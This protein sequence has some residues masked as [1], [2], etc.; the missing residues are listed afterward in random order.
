MDEEI[1]RE[2]QFRNRLLVEGED[3]L[4]VCIHLLKAHQI[5]IL[6][7]ERS[8]KNKTVGK[9]EIEIVSKGGVERLLAILSE[10]LQGSDLKH[11]GVLVDADEDFTNR[12]RSLRDILVNSGYSTIPSIPH[13]EGTIIK[14]SDKPTVGIWIMPDNQLPGM[15]EHFCES[16]VPT[17]D[18]LW[19]TAGIALH[20][21]IEQDRRF[22]EKHMIKAHLHT[23]LAWQEEP[24]KPVGQAITKRY[25]DHQAAH[26]QQFIQWIRQLFEAEP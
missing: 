4:H 14:E 17:N 10:E 1:V 7:K 11:L 20:Q 13:R 6:E 25:L 18:P 21:V 12:W 16:L 15:L 5:K 3:D 22:P 19:A 2:E 9:G 8:G 23:W 26:A 24:G